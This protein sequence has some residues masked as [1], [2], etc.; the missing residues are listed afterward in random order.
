MREEVFPLLGVITP[1]VINLISTLLMIV[2]M[3]ISNFD[4]TSCCDFTDVLSIYT[5]HTCLILL[6]V[7][8]LMICPE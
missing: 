5:N 1:S 6:P 8:N 4:L 3:G 7:V 2:S